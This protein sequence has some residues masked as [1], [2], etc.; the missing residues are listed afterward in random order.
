LRREE[1]R[2]VITSFLQSDPRHDLLPLSLRRYQEYRKAPGSPARPSNVVA[3]THGGTVGYD[4]DDKGDHAVVYFG[5][6]SGHVLMR[7]DHLVNVTSQKH[8]RWKRAHP[9]FC[10][11][12]G[13][14]CFT[15]PS[16]LAQGHQ[17]SLTSP[18][19]PAR[20]AEVVSR[21]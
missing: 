10:R 8:E 11:Q 7:R 1:S 19:T 15:P 18:P 20:A 13:I 17:S 12:M 5:S 2:L 6:R 4:D 3:A 21:W 9:E 14:G 16:T